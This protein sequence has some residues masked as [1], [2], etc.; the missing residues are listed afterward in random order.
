ML[1]QS[2]SLRASLASVN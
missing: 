1:E 2:F